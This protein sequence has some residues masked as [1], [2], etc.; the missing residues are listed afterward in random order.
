MSKDKLDMLIMRTV[1]AICKY[2][3]THNELSFMTMQEYVDV[4]ESADLEGET[5]DT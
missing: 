1:Y 5:Y 4:I 2:L 3:L